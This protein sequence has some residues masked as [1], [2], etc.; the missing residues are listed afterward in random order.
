MRV[1]KPIKVHRLIERALDECG[2]DLDSAIKSLNDFRLGSDE[3]LRPV[4]AAASFLLKFLHLVAGAATTNSETTPPENTS[5]A[6]V[7]HMEST[8]WV[9]LFVGEMMNDAKT[10]GSRAL[11]VFEKAICA[12]ATE[13]TC[14]VQQENIMLKQQLE[15]L[16]HENAIL[17]RAVAIQHERQKEFEDRGHKL[18]QLKQPVAQYQEQ[19]RTLEVKFLFELM[20]FLRSNFSSSSLEPLRPIKG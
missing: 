11:E 3:N 17:K 20:M 9:E 14:S 5:A 1:S 15:A 19:L 2:G 16:M 6:K 8:E 4:T 7:M 18:N 13:A 12:R 10:R